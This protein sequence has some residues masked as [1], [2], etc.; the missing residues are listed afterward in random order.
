MAYSRRKCYITNK[1]GMILAK[2]RLNVEMKYMKDK[3]WKQGN[4]N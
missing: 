1:K 3:D 4:R 2:Y